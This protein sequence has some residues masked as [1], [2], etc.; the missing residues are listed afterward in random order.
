[1]GSEAMAVS[2]PYWFGSQARSKAQSEIVAFLD[3]N[4]Q[5]VESY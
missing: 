4:G 5:K 1:M 2:Y 3:R